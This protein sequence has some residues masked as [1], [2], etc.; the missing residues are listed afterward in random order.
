MLAADTL[1]WMRMALC[2]D[3]DPGLFFPQ[4][5]ESTDQAKAVCAC[6]PVTAE[7]LVHALGLRGARW[8]R[9]G[10]FGGT[11]GRERKRLR[12]RLKPGPSPP[13]TLPPWP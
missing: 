12:A 6:C 1:G 7:C 4:R 3:M 2:Q 13:L 8:E 11:S 10:I 9:D 5:G